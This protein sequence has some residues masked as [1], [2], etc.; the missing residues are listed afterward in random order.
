MQNL[1]LSSNNLQ[2]S[3]SQTQPITTFK[4][5][6]LVMVTATNNNKYY[7]MRQISDDTFSVSYGRVGQGAAINEYSMYQWESKYREKVRKGYKDVTHLFLEEL[8]NKSSKFKI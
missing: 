7:E 2:H 5:A 3:T 4:T 6:K 1:V 8:E